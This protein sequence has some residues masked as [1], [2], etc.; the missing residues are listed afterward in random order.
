MSVKPILCGLDLGSKTC[1]IAVSDGLGMLA[2]PV[3]TLRFSHEDYEACLE[4][5]APIVS[6]Y[7]VAQFVLGFPKSLNN[8]ISKRAQVSEMFKASLEKAFGL[9]VQLVDERFT[10][11]F[12]TKNLISL[13]KKR[14]ERKEIIDQAA[15]VAILQS[16]LD[17]LKFKN[18]E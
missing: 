11:V 8:V 9:P 15:A 2:H 18:G 16:Y 10:T 3:T 4:L 17:Q 1:G 13:N 12:S 6:Q 5:L 14:K 7:Q